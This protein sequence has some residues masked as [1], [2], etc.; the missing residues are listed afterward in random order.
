MVWS[1]HRFRWG[2]VCS[3]CGSN[4]DTG[5]RVFIVNAPG[6]DVGEPES[7]PAC[8]EVEYSMLKR[9]LH[10]R[11]CQRD[12]LVIKIRDLTDNNKKYKE[13][14]ETRE[15]SKRQQVV[16]KTHASQLSDR[17]HLI[18]SLQAVIED[19]EATITQLDRRIHGNNTSG[20]TNPSSTVST[21]YPLTSASAHPTSSF[22]SSPSSSSPTDA[23]SSRT[24]GTSR[25]VADIQ[26]L[27]DE[28]TKLVS[29][30][31]EAQAQ[32]DVCE[33]EHSQKIAALQRSLA[34]R[35]KFSSHHGGTKKNIEQGI[36]D[37]KTGSCSTDTEKQLEKVQAENDRLAAEV[38]SLHR[39]YTRK[40]SASYSF[41]A[42][43]FRKLEDESE[44]L[45]H[46]L[47][48]AEACMQ[49]KEEYWGE[50]EAHLR[51]Q[52]AQAHNKMSSH[53]NW[54]EKESTLRA[55]I[56]GAHTEK[57]QTAQQLRDLQAKWTALQAK[58]PDVI[59][60]IIQVE[61]ESE[62]LK[63]QVGELTDKVLDWERHCADR[64]KMV[65]D[66]QKQIEFLNDKLEK[67]AEERKLLQECLT[68]E[69]EKERNS[70]ELAVADVRREMEKKMYDLQVTN[71]QMKLKLAYLASSFDG[72]KQ[73]YILLSRQARQFP[74][75][76]AITLR[77]T[78]EKMLSA[79]K[80]VGEEN[81]SLVRKYHK[82]MKL[83]K[84]YHNELVELKGNIRVFCRVRPPIKEDGTGS[85][86]DMVVTYDP[87]DDGLVYISNKGR[88][89]TFDFDRVFSPISTQCQVFDEVSALVTSC[90][91]GFNVCIFA[92][93]QTGSGKTYT[94][95]GPSG[96]QGI[97]QRALAELFQE[98]AD[99]GDDWHY[100]I[101]VSVLEI[102]NETIRDLLSADN[103]NK[104]DVK[105]KGEGGFHVPGLVTVTVS[106][107]RDVNQV[108]AEGKKNRATAT[109][110]M[111]EH[112]SRSHCLLCVTVTGVNRTTSTRSFGRLNLVD[113]AG[114]ERVSKSGADGTRLK[115]A[116]NI[117]KSLSCLGDVIHALRV[118]QNHIPFRNSKLTYLLQD[119]LGGDSKTLMI[120]QVAPVEKNVSETVCSLTFGQR[121]R[122][123][124][125]G[126]AS[127]KIETGDFE[128]IP[129][130]PK[131][132]TDSPALKK[133][134]PS[135]PST[136]SPALQSQSRFTPGKSSPANRVTRQT[137]RK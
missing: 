45:H 95:E 110:N 130:S 121:V 67:G 78:Q 71:Q 93:G 20:T 86:A 88:I 29:Q 87:D 31:A 66:M 91:D 40:P 54:Q 135:S 33:A 18:A 98:T 127:R 8:S 50:Q 1:S 43:D 38:S 48:E 22:P 4:R 53:S 102:Y 133:L 63:E 14:L 49:Q 27:H 44:Q 68:E 114:S 57:R 73:A 122:S 137:S 51:A 120:V 100:T 46:Q 30:L 109:T 96:D 62:G 74:Q 59:T 75:M 94:M 19:Q 119:S 80:D 55:E 115:E 25:L 112:S 9:E 134:G 81:K 42:E 26:C 10:E 28:K 90:I 32:L 15:T 97:N 126:A 3:N 83:R 6:G 111:N 82:E 89:Q 79:V 118:K 39:F 131:G 35:E 128:K 136:K 116:Q 105:M 5:K 101:D 24:G 58:D 125:L 70:K 132:T 92:Y 37:T 7:S 99:R 124:E 11:N 72:V 41:Q 36:H 13:R 104:L 61:V 47:Q 23:E 16:T 123:V 21:S 12:D 65:A 60:K 129:T 117:N 113:L 56:T 85:Q 103:G 64:D 76:V 17:D 107:Q 84:K 34:E 52:L 77:E 69:A 106:S 2:Y 108:F